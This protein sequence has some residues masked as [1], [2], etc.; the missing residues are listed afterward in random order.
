MSKQITLNA[1]AV[2]EI[3]FR[4]NDS[5][6]NITLYYDVM[7]DQDQVVGQKE[8]RVLINDLPAATKATITTFLTKL[9]AILSAKD[10]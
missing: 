7:D 9:T 10:L 6:P 1:V 8:H 3:R 2:R 4:P 5:E